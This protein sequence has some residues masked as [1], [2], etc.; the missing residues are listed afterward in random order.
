MLTRNT[1]PTAWPRSCS[2]CWRKCRRCASR[3]APPPFRSRER[4][5]TSEPSPPSCNWPPCS[6]AWAGLATA[7]FW[8]ADSAD[9]AHDLAE[10]QK[11]ARAAAEKAVALGPEVPEGY[12]ARGLI[13]SSVDYDW[14]GAKAD[15][16]R[17]LA[18]SPEDA[19]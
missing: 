3:R 14:N 2:I 7:E 1:S 10:G 12:A 11:R 6:P 19:D 18:I 13:R 9:S 17:A 5:R 15:F 16:E 8:I 4:T